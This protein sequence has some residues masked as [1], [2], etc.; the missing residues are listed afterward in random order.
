MRKLLIFILFLLSPLLCAAPKLTVFIVVDGL[1][2]QSMQDLQPY[3]SQGGLRTLSEEAYQAPV[4]FPQLVYGG[5]EATATM[6]TGLTP[7]YHNYQTDSYF[8]RSDRKPHQLLTDEKQTGIH[9]KETLSPAALTCSTLADKHRLNEGSQAKIYA[10]GVNPLTT[11]LLAGHA[12]NACCWIENNGWGSTTYYSE[13][14]P[15]AADRM[16]SNGSFD[17]AAKRTWTNRMDM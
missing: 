15:S 8:R 9:S 4:M 14:L 11:V 7:F 5:D 2:M 10:I 13:G 16:N 6:L 1:D 3:W 12:A 17:E